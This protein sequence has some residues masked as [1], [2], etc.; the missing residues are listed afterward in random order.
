MVMRPAEP[1]IMDTY[2]L[3]GQVAAYEVNVRSKL[4]SAL[5]TIILVLVCVTQ[6]TIRN[7]AESVT[8]GNAPETLY[9]PA[10]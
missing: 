1:S 6:Y 4:P 2:V 9:V 7:P 8:F 3:P 10:G 5:V